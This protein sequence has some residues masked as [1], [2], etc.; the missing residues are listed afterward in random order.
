MTIV[1]KQRDKDGNI[2]VFEQDEHGNCSCLGPIM[3][4]ENN[5][6][7]EE[8]TANENDLTEP[9]LPST[10]TRTSTTMGLSFAFTAAVSIGALPMLLFGINTGASNFLK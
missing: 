1:H 10:A 9:L 5:Q 7:P 2:R 4:T 6:Q 3:S 8:A